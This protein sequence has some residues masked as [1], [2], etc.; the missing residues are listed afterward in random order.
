MAYPNSKFDGGLLD[1]IG[2]QILA[3]LIVIFTLGI[4]TPWA[5]CMTYGWKIN[6]TI[7]EG[8]RLKFT[9]TA[10]GLFGSWIK[11]TLLCI[12]TCG[13]YSFWVFIALEN[14]KVSNT[15]FEDQ[16]VSIA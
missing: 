15:T 14:W 5:I 9:G 3:T 12:I 6:H 8:R 13:I 7:V 16:V 11:W 4:C 2:V 10:M 1:Y